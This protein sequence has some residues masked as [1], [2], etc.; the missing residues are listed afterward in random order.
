MLKT[1][2][3]LTNLKMLVRS[4]KNN[5]DRAPYFSSV[6]ILVTALSTPDN[7]NVKT[8]L[9]GRLRLVS[10]SLL[11]EV[12]LVHLSNKPLLNPMADMFSNISTIKP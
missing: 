12:P 8:H 1:N 5:I 2:D 4:L 3:I 10:L 6:T 9:D 11:R 7:C